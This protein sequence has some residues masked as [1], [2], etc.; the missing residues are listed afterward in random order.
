MKKLLTLAA[1]AAAMMAL[2]SCGGEQKKTEECKFNAEKYAEEHTARLNEIVTLT[3]EQ[4]KEVKAIFLEEAKEVEANIKDMKGECKK[5]ECKKAE[6]DKAECNKAECKKAECDKAECKKAEC[7]KAE[8]KKAE[9]DKAEC[10]KAECNKAECK[11]AECDKAECKKAECDKANCNKAECKKNGHKQC[12]V[13]PATKKA[14]MEKI[15][16][17]LTPE[18]VALLDAHRAQKSEC[19][20]PA[21]CCTG[22]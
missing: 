17:L 14:N 9:C 18:Q 12:M 7:D 20:K 11:K 4:S 13:S 16:A 15:K 5:A 22:K 6:C 2:T 10:K 19:M 3:E 1:M 21:E 8:C